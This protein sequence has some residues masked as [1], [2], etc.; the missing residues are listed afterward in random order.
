MWMN[1]NCESSSF[2]LKVKTEWKQCKLVELIEKVQTM[3]LA[4]YGD[5]RK[6]LTGQGPYYLDDTFK[7]RAMVYDEWCNKSQG[8]RDRIFQL[9]MID[10]GRPAQN[11]CQ[12]TDGHRFVP[13]TPSGGKKTNQCK[14]KRSK[15]CRSIKKRKITTEDN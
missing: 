1:N 11:I 13:V 15:T 5:I 3:A 2:V 10:T 4:R 12:S 14:R 8:Q 6:A 9:F 7:H